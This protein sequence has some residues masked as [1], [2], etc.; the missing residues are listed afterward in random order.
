M[1]IT[2]MPES[3]GVGGVKAATAVM[4]MRSFTS[5]RSALYVT[6]IVNMSSPT[7]RT[8]GMLK[9][10]TTCITTSPEPSAA[11]LRLSPAGISTICTTSALE[12]LTLTLRLHEPDASAMS[13]S[14]SNRA[15]AA[16]SLSACKPT[17]VSWVEP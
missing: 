4:A 15:L 3:A 11:T 2:T 12:A 6:S 10:L 7:A 14:T 13:R 1:S 16:N 17:T 9:R 5:I 8:S